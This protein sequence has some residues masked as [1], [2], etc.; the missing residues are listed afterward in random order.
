[1]MRPVGLLVVRDDFELLEVNLRYH[2]Q[3]GFERFV[4]AVHALPEKPIA[5]DQMDRLQ[6]LRRD[7][8]PVVSIG[9]VE[10]M[11][12]EQRSIQQKLLDAHS[13]GD[14]SKES[15]LI[16]L[17]VDEF[18]WCRDGLREFLASVPVEPSLGGVYA[19]V[20]HFNMLHDV[21]AQRPYSNA[22]DSIWGYFPQVER[23]WEMQ[24]SLYKSIV[25]WHE[26]I[27]IFQGGHFF[28]SVANW[29]RIVDRAQAV[30]FHYTQRGTPSQLLD[31]WRALASPRLQAPPD[32]RPPWWEKYEVLAA[33]LDRY[34]KNTLAL[35][36]DWFR[37]PKSFWGTEIPADKIVCTTAMRDLLLPLR[38]SRPS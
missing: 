15:V 4:I 12:F 25:S 31:K 10:S 23:E 13:K 22:L 2:V 8:A 20:L 30:L 7:L 36:H 19:A 33:R 18:L 29:P 9:F 11:S 6:D 38:S 26:G 35:E 17:D 32:I 5:S 27:E 16:P 14:D 24:S 37:S 21:P 3:L 1:M 28:T 34:E